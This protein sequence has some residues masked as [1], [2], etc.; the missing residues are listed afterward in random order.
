MPASAPVS[1]GGRLRGVRVLVPRPRERARDLCF[2]LE[3]EGAEVV[4]LPLL[5][6]EPPTD[7]RPLQAAAEL[8]RRFRWVVFASERG[9]ASLV[10]AARTAGTLDV[11]RSR[12][13]AAIGP[14]TAAA[15][16]AHGLEAELVAPVS[17]AEGLAEA[18]L[19]RLEASDAVLLPA[20]EDGRRA[21]EEALAAA[22][23]AVERVAAYRS[24]AHSATPEG[25]G[26]VCA[27]PPRCVLFGSPRTVE[28]FLSLPGAGALTTSVRAVAIGPTTA[29]ALQARGWLPAAVAPTPTPEAWLEAAVRA[30]AG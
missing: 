21:L 26:E 28:A 29:A 24:S 20:A 18:L 17:T 30:I 19:P 15:L 3:E 27:R 10:E 5:E 23:I 16:A 25:W 12:K 22:G 2:L 11:L 4:A 14:G 9:V 8:L 6:L 13:L 7:P 1:E